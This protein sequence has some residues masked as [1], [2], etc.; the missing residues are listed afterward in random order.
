M[1]H[2]IVLWVL[3]LPS[4]LHGSASKSQA[5]RVRRWKYRSAGRSETRVIGRI[6]LAELFSGRSENHSST[7]PG[8]LSGGGS[9]SRQDQFLT[10]GNPSSL[11]YLILAESLQRILL[12]R[13]PMLRYLWYLLFGPK[14]CVTCHQYNA[15]AN[16]LCLYCQVRRTWV[17]PAA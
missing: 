4:G 17:R 2:S 3:T 14:L 13:C 8:F 6:R 11:K 1:C 9:M 7:P 16:S 10:R 15:A 12:W 5:G